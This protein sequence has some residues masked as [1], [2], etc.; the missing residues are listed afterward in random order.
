VF[1]RLDVDVEGHLEGGAEIAADFAERPRQTRG[2]RQGTAQFVGKRAPQLVEAGKA[3]RL[4]GTHHRRIAGPYARRQRRR[5][6]DEDLLAIIAK[7]GDDALLGRAHLPEAIGDALIEAQCRHIALMN[8]E[9]A[10]IFIID[11]SIYYISC[12]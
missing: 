1:E 2:K 10:T 5:R 8:I 3:E 6:G 12:R 4:G 11:C 7:K 9:Y